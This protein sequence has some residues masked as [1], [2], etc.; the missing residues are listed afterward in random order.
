MNNKIKNR[1]EVIFIYDVNDANPNGDT[2]ENRPLIDEET[3]IN[4]VTDVRLKRTIRDY[5]YY[6]K[7]KEIFVREER[8]EEGNLKTRESIYEKYGSPEKIIEKCIDIRL[9]GGTFALKKREGKKKKETIEGV[10]TEES[11]GGSFAITGPI[12]FK[13][14]RSLHKVGE[15]VYVRGTTIL[16]SGEKKGAG[17]FWE[18][19]I[20]NY[21][22]ICFYG[23][24]NENAA[25][26]TN[27]MEEDID[28]LL[29]G[30]WNGTKNLITRSKIGQNPRLLLQVIYKEKN[31]H[32]GE[33][34]KR[35]KL[36]SNL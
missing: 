22:L 28:F 15:P 33:L 1:S 34:D 23:I 25:K 2:E 21:S 36:I 30:I 16:P 4:I 29:E 14:G 7:G 3:G 5:L 19:Y 11:V 26:E 8:D 35:I 20:L 27:L 18:S 9:F 32:I 6:F 12:Q 24:I 17:T 31:Y 10:D 13:F